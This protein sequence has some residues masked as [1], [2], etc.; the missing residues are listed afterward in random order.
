MNA[1]KIFNKNMY[2][3]LGLFIGVAFFLNESIICH[4]SVICM[5]FTTTGIKWLS[6]A[7]NIYCISL[8]RVSSSDGW[9]IMIKPL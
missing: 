2:S 3:N 7:L 1:Q 9:I 8:K 5:S 6:W 4:L